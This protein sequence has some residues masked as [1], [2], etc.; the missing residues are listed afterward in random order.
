MEARTTIVDATTWVCCAGLSALI[1]MVVTGA[2]FE[3]KEQSGLLGAIVGFIVG[4]AGGLLCLIPLWLIIAMAVQPANFCPR[5]GRRYSI[6]ATRCPNC[7]YPD[8]LPP[9]GGSYAPGPQPA[10]R[11]LRPVSVAPVRYCSRCNHPME[12]STRYCPNCGHRNM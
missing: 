2:Q 5:C 7:W 3:R 11:L 10:P 12:T 9:Y 8:P 4:L 1:G 6:N